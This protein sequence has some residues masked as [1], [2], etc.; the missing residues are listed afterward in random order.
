MKDNQKDQIR[1]L[2]R[3]INSSKKIVFL[4]GAGVSIESGIPDFR[5]STG[6][7]TSDKHAE[8]RPEQIVSHSYFTQNTSEFFK[9]YLT[10]MVH[11]NAVPNDAHKKLAELEKAGKLSAIITQNID[12]LHEM[13]GS[14]NVID[15]H[16]TIYENHCTKCNESYTLEEL[17]GLMKKRK[18]NVPICVM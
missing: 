12:G 7:F 1:Q 17:M 2:Q 10:R 3:I 11:P 15:I 8:L 14:K 16:G 4:G 9:Y 5:S 18:K 13:A 6:I